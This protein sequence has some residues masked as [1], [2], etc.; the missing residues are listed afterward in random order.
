MEEER[1]CRTCRYFPCTKPQ[2]ELTKQGC[3]DYESI[4]EAEIK[5]IGM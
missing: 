2:C 4:V 5:R 3:N 1:S